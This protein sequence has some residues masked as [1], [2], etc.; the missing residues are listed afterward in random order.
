MG[1]DIHDFTDPISGQKLDRGLAVFGGVVGTAAVRRRSKGHSGS[2]D[3]IEFRHWCFG[4]TLDLW[5]RALLGKVLEA[6]ALLGKY[7]HTDLRDA[8]ILEAK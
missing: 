6:Q 7:F 4:H 5:K 3:R 1:R 8:L 2:S